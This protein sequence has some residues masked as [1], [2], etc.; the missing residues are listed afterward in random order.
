MYYILSHSKR[1]V[2]QIMTQKDQV[3]IVVTRRSPESGNSSESGPHLVSVPLLSS[4]LGS[5]SQN[6]LT[7]EWV[8][9]CNRL[10]LLHLFWEIFLPGSRI[11]FP[12]LG[13]HHLFSIRPV[14]NENA[15]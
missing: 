5:L 2:F 1:I 13:Y 11:I 3:F 14:H 9:Q 15:T 7:G 4:V 12:H 8:Y 6:N 10:P